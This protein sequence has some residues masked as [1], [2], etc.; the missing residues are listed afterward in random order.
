[1]G[2]YMLRK[3]LIIS[4][5]LLIFINII[6]AQTHISV[7]LGHPVYLILEQAQI[8]GIIGFQPEIKPYS[9]SKITSLINE[10]LENDDDRR[11][12]KLT[13]AERGILEEF[14]NDLNPERG[15]LD[16]IKGTVSAQNTL[17]DIYV[18]GEFGFGL[19]L[20]FGLGYFSAAGGYQYDADDGKYFEGASHPAEGDLYTSIEILPTISFHGDLGKN[21]SYGLILYGFIGKVPRAVF[22]MYDN[23]D[24]EMFP[25]EGNIGQYKPLTIRSEPLTAFPYTYKKRWD[26]FL[27]PVSDVSNSSHVA[28]PESTAIGYLMMP[29]LAGELFGGHVFLRFARIDREWAGASPNGSLILNQ[30]AQAFLGFESLVSPFPW[31]A[32]SSLTGV[33]EYHN[34]VGDSNSAEI[35]D[36]SGAFQNAFSIVQLEV[37]YKNYAGLGLGSSVVWPK[38]FELGYVFPLAENFMYQNNIGDFDNLA[39]FLNLKGQ[40][41]GIGKLWFSLFLDEISFEPNFSILDR[42]MFAYQIGGSFNIPWLP[43][44]SLKISY[45]K[46]EPYN[47]THNKIKTPWYTGLMEQ[48]YVNFG[49]SLGHYI[50]PNSDEILVRFETIPFSRS[51]IGVQYQLIRHGADYGDRAVDGSSLWSELPTSGDRSLL[52]KDFLKDGAYQWMHIIKLGGEY[53]FTG[54]KLPLKMFAEAGA[55]Y[56][57]FTDVDGGGY[58][59]ID[60]PQYPHSLQFILNIGIKIFPKF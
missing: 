29:E 44:A 51:M 5:F 31:I 40:Y 32:I 6:P 38:R 21:L 25:G 55:V 43:F 26:A 13:D 53:S 12:G 10:I 41:P 58:K 35:H 33:L 45:T 11:F 52:E 28:W 50:P 19:D 27:F 23:M 48:N 9:R 3:P 36:I 2:A 1:M 17:N 8:R 54:I 34:A 57:Y 42:N 56:S 22:G 24:N 47:Y 37:N 7:P 20:N 46:N 39:L 60:T 4:L 30:S 15:K 18:S 49:R 14:I 16:L 59:I